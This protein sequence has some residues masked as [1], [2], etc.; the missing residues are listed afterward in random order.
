MPGEPRD[1]AQGAA[2]HEVGETRAAE[3]PRRITQA[4]GIDQN[5]N[6]HH[7]ADRVDP[8]GGRQRRGVAHGD[9][10]D[11]RLRSRGFPE[12]TGRRLGERAARVT[13]ER[14]DGRPALQSGVW[15]L[16]GRLAR[17]WR[18]RGRQRKRRQEG[19]QVQIRV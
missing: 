2:A 14:D 1:L 10:V 13:E 18:I 16:A 6:G 19:A 8:A 15:E 12:P 7:P 9:P 17:L 3:S 11:V 5:P 4:L